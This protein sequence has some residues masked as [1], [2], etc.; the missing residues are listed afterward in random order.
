MGNQML[1]WLLKITIVI[2]SDLLLQVLNLL[3]WW[4]VIQFDD[5]LLPANHLCYVTS[6]LLFLDKS[7]CVEFWWHQSAQCLLILCNV[8]EIGLNRMA[9]I[10][11]IPLLH[12]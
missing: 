5:W 2:C 7:F 11:Y 1:S 10:G 9:C 4:P 12:T 3:Y 6:L 8:F